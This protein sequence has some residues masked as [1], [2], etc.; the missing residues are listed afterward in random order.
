ML[1]LA[2]AAFRRTPF[3]QTLFT[4]VA[5]LSGLLVLTACTASELSYSEDP[6]DYRNEVRMLQQRLDDDPS[7][8]AALR[9]LGAIYMQTR[10]P[11]RAYDTLKRSYAHVPNDPKTLFYLG[12]ASESVGRENAALELFSQ[13]DAVPESSRYRSLMEGRYEWIV[14][15][16]A[17]TEI[18]GLMTREATIADR[19]V[20]PRILA[21]LPFNYRGVSDQYE[22][23]GR[24]LAEMM[25]ADLAN[26][27]ELRVVERVRLQ[28]IL[29]EVEFGQSDYVDRRS[30]PRVGRLLG[31]GRLAGGSFR[32]TQER[33]I[34]MDM[35][36]LELNA[37][38][39]PS[40]PAKTGA[41]AD[42]FSMQK[43]LVLALLDAINVSLT[44]AER[45]AISPVPTE[46]L[47]AFLAFSR[48]LLEE[49][50]DNFSAAAQH[51]REATTID[52]GFS[53]AAERATQAE[54][55][56]TAGGTAQNALSAA[57]EPMQSASALIQQRLNNMGRGYLGAEDLAEGIE[58]TPAEE[59][60]GAG[61][62]LLPLPPDPPVRP[63]P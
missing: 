14:R 10:R 7:D 5:A 52:P 49:D 6:S 40:V 55:L 13:Y 45:A 62:T 38:S 43:D 47:D 19:E 22:P 58:R 21:V 11:N 37:D 26:V 60:D 4:V 18:R 42:L 48:G 44:D 50:R 36:V 41:L 8:A 3:P 1:S 57:A 25:I 63:D 23:L 30:A 27:R 54:A 20:S 31:A 51:Y 9:D 53:I 39:T 35:V 61:S 2:H 24:G 28:A 17:R 59:A 29:R 33:D 46:S 34:R 32:V 12:M 16:Q 56:S 15:Q